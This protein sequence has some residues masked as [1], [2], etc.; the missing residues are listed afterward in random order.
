MATVTP[1]H[2]ENCCHLVSELEAAVSCLCSSI[3]QLLIYV[4]SMHRTLFTVKWQRKNKIFT[5]NE[6]D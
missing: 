4:Y 2:A 6:N 1:F 3:R 5:N